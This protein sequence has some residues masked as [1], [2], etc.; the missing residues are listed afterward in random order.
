MGPAF[1]PAASRLTAPTAT[2]AAFEAWRQ[3]VPFQ[4]R[5]TMLSQNSWYI[6]TNREP[7]ITTAQQKQ[8]H[9]NLIKKYNIHFDG[10]IDA[11][12]W[13]SSHRA[14]FISIKKLGRSEFVEYR[15]SVAVDSEEKLWRGY[16]KHRA[17][18]ISNW[19]ES[20]TMAGRMKQAGECPWNR[21]YWLDL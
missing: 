13:P 21:K 5:Y 14:T 3:P 6:R 17:E 16:A 11:E 4:H 9:H 8:E 7:N 10:P 15:E 18:Q 20:A 1:Q 19:R 12:E 2:A